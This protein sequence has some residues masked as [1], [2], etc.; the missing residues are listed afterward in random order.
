MINSHK[1]SIKGYSIKKIDMKDSH[2]STVFAF[3]QNLFIQILI[4]TT[5]Q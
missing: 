1:K 4:I 5:L 3:L 2:C